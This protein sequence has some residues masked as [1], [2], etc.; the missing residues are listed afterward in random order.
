M[1][2]ET[3][4]RRVFGVLLDTIVAEEEGVRRQLDPEHLHDLRVG[5][6]RTRALLAEARK[7]LPAKLRRTFR[8]EFAWLGKL[9]GPARDL[10]VHLEQLSELPA[11]RNRSLEPLIES[12]RADRGAEQRRLLSGLDSDRYRRL[13]DEWRAF[14]ER[15]TPDEPLPEK[16]ARP[17]ELLAAKRIRRAHRAVLEQ[18][19]KIGRRGSAKKMHR[20]RIRCKKLRYLLEFFRELYDDDDM[21]PLI[22]SL[23][24]LQDCLGEFNDVQ[25]QRATLRRFAKRTAG[26]AHAEIERMIQELGPREE[27]AREQFGSRFAEFGSSE[28]AER[29]RRLFPEPSSMPPPATALVLS[30][31]ALGLSCAIDGASGPP[32]DTY[33]STVLLNQDPAV[34]YVGRQA[35]K[36]CHEA[37]Y[38][39]FTRTGMGRSFYPMG[40]EAV[41]EDFDTDNVV[42]ADSG[43]RYRTYRRDGK[44]YQKQFL[45][46]SKG[47]EIASDERELIWAVGSNNH[48]RGYVTVQSG[49]LFQAPVCWDPTTSSWIFCPGFESTNHNF[50]REISHTCVFCHNGRME[51][52]AGERNRYLEPLPHGIGCERCH[53]PGQLH[54]VGKGPVATDAGATIVNPRRLPRE[55]RLHVCFQCHLGDSS[56]TE[57]VLRVDRE[58]ESFR[59]GQPIT[60][61][62]VPFRYVEPSAYEFGIG[63]QADRMILS[64]C[65]TESEDQLECLTCHNPHITTYDEERPANFFR[66]KCMYCHG[67]DGCTASAEERDRTDL[68][69]DCVACHMRRGE[70]AD[71]RHA[72]FTDHWI[73]RDIDVEPAERTNFDLEPVFPERFA[74]LSPGEQAFYRGRANSLRARLEPPK[75]RSLLWER[76]GRGYLEAVS[77]GYD[78]SDAR[79]FL[80]KTYMFRGRHTEAARAFDAA[81]EREPRHHDAAFA[82]GQSLAAMG[83][84]RQAATVFATML[85]WDADDPMALSELGSSLWSMKL[86]DEAIELYRHAL[87]QEP[88]NANLHLN[89]AKVL[90]SAGQMRDAADEAGRAVGLD[91]D[92]IDAWE[93]YSE[94]MRRAGR[95]D[96]AEEGLLQVERLKQ[97]IRPDPGSGRRM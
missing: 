84:V 49:G 74:A 46:D 32:P 8:D 26:D 39:T 42:V 93:F 5:V 27:T 54:V 97:V 19:A 22:R 11:E 50:G 60:D 61:V 31:L 59:P 25:V 55:E 13:V 94:L 89:L 58:L 88:W 2:A 44:Y 21:R 68:P 91:P 38:A 67:N 9:T 72:Q 56:N 18:G 66:H 83:Q 48:G 17:I 36:S 47:R 76:A 35:C 15:G 79:F 64:R 75:A 20:L 81:L 28:N 80:G 16:A 85:E 92:R 41:V 82:L 73:R 43:L 23:K 62:I 6:R 40:P 57:R 12:L 29:F 63:S 95:P 86:Y 4:A 1:T 90:A 45:L 87:E 77:A 7:V 52:V 69:D 70:P 34:R 30:L 33:G 3:A 96:D 24:R 71:R 37:N 78:T 14:V 10:D 51:R 65:Y 53:G